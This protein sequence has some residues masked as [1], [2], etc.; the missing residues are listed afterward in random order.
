MD[1]VYGEMKLMTSGASG[2]SFV[3]SRWS[4]LPTRRKDRLGPEGLDCLRL[5]AGAKQDTGVVI[6]R[7][8]S[9]V[10]PAR[11][12]GRL[13]D[14]FYQRR[15]YRETTF[16]RSDP[17]CVTYSVYIY[18]ENEALLFVR[19]CNTQHTTPPIYLPCHLR[20]YRRQSRRTL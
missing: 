8:W 13:D 12:L 6:K 20:K 3:T 5:P 9:A 17:S 4:I 15:W 16:G 18:V 19:L 7:H 10:W 2:R 1:R 11:G 14:R